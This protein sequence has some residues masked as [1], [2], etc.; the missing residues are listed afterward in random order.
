MTIKAGLIGT[1]GISGVHL[2]YLQSRDDVE[3][4]ALCDIKPEA[5]ER[6]RS[7]FGGKG[8]DH[9]MKMLDAVELDAVWLCTPPEVRQEMLVECADRGIPV[10]C[11]KPVERTEEKAAQIARELRKRNAHV[12]IG[13]VF[14]ATPIVRKLRDLM[15][16]DRIHL[17]QSF[18]GCDMSIKREFPEWFFDKDQSGGGLVDQATH[19]LD[20]LRY[21]FGEVT[22]VVGAASNPY[23]KK[24]P[25]YTIDET[26]GLTFLFEN[27]ML[28]THS[29]TWVGDAWRNY[30]AFSGEKR[31]YG[32]DM[33]KQQIT[34][35]EGREAATIEFEQEGMYTHEN[36]LFLEMLKSGDWT[37]NM[38]DYD[39]GL[40]TLRLTLA[41]DRSI[42]DG[43]VKL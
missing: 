36:A 7:E 5:L 8:F 22:E 21:L 19:N 37:G 40:A 28:G 11:E 15:D 2:K 13:Y 38:C 31:H 42:T 33:C 10:F 30:L 35:L 39:D 18:Y 25:G 1:G 23:K 24:E 17:V 12:M 43:K 29:H 32:L 27:G 6:R 20:M 3:I 9:F 4:V 34:L 16:D 26:I 41:A 14:R